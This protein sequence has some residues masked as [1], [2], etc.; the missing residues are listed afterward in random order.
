MWPTFQK[1]ASE[2][3][4]QLKKYTDGVSASGSV[5]GFFGRG[6]STTDV[7]VATVSIR[8]HGSTS[9]SSIIESIRSAID[10]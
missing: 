3:V 7:S 5:G 8:Y 9:S 1:V 10:M 4:E 2:H 6:V